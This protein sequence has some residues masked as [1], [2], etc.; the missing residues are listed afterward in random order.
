MTN[1]SN[2]NYYVINVPQKK[3]AC[4]NTYE[5]VCTGMQTYVRA[6]THTHTHC[7]ALRNK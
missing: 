4:T 7:Q 3:G 6:H 5:Q 2:Y 1:E